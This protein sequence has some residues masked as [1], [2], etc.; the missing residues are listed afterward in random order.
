MEIITN[1]KFSED[2]FFKA[3]CEKAH[4]EPTTRQAS[5]FRME[6]GRAFKVR[7]QVVLNTDKKE[8]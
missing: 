2:G 3:C 6:K 7:K 8:N 4:V 1:K 5:K